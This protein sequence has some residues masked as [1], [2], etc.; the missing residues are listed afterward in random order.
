MLNGHLESIL[1][2]EVSTTSVVSIG[3]KRA[4]FFGTENFNFQDL[5]NIRGSKR[6]QN[7]F[8]LRILRS[9][10]FVHPASNKPEILVLESSEDKTKAKDQFNSLSERI[11]G[12]SGNVRVIPKEL[13]TD[14]VIDYIS[15]FQRE[16]VS[17]KIHPYCSDFA[18]IEGKRTR[19]TKVI[20]SL[21]DITEIQD[22]S[23]LTGWG[24]YGAEYTIKRGNQKLWGFVYFDANPTARIQAHLIAY[25][26]YN[27]MAREL[28]NRL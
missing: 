20:Y 9:Q 25:D 10:C 1:S 17:F 23:R 15:H 14:S 28:V 11:R 12:T 2:E 8:V 6:A 5:G 21:R 27:D 22:V 18:E 24:I 7:G 16:I 3:Y 4:F 26:I 19:R 13:N